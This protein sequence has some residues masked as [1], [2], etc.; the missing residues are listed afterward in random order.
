MKLSNEPLGRR[1]KGS[2]LK[3]KKR[4][5]KKISLSVGCIFNVGMEL[6][7]TVRLFEVLCDF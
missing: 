2:I 6:F 1:Q 5:P 3:E 4:P 7:Q